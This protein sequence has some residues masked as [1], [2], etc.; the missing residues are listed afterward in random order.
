MQD[1]ADQEEPLT[2][3]RRHPSAPWQPLHTERRCCA[4]SLWL[5]PGQE[6]QAY[7]EFQRVSAPR[8]CSARQPRQRCPLECRSGS[9]HH[10]TAACVVLVQHTTQGPVC[11]NPSSATFLRTS[12]S[13]V[14]IPPL[15]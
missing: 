1:R 4:K 5:Y 2:A 12:E 14:F 7:E 8:W 9:T 15:Y 10:C 3:G 13:I 11:Y 6:T